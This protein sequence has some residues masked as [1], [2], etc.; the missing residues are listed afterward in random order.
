[1]SHD[2]A[3]KY[4]KSNSGY[5]RMKDLKQMGIHPR[6]LKDFISKKMVQKI[7]P[8]IY[9]LIDVNASEYQHFVDLCIAIPKGVICIYSALNYY[10]LSEY[11]PERIMLAVPQGCRLPKIENTDFQGFFF[12]P[13]MYFG[14]I[15]E[16]ELDGGIFRI[17][18]RE[19]ALVDA[20]RFKS[21]FGL[22]R[23]QSALIRY[24]KSPHRHLGRL[25][26][27]ARQCKVLQAM[28]PFLDEV[29]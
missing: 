25:L 27:L 19:K 5:A 21:R 15:E 29:M 11:K 18:S 9:R 8:G 14:D 24:T 2:E 20:F 3:L 1:M 22:E 6:V 16:I 12:S 10:G 26:V 7:K 17:Y 13:Q 28:L 4:F 23:A